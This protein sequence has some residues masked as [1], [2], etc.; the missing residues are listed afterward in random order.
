MY[1][2]DLEYSREKYLQLDKEGSAIVFAVK[3]FHQYIYGRRFIIY[4]NHK[5]LEH[6]FVNYKPVPS[7]AAARVQQRVL[8]LGGYDYQIIYCLGKELGHADGLS[9]LPLL[10]APAK[11]LYQERP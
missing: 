3:N 10:E 11:Y 8:I 1:H 9:R 5:P 4:S 7:Q 6:M 2:P